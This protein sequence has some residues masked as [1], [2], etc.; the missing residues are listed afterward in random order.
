MTEAY[1]YYKLTYEPKGSGELKNKNKDYN[2]YGN[3]TPVIVVGFYPKITWQV[4]CP[5]CFWCWKI[6][7]TL[8]LSYQRKVTL[9]LFYLWWSFNGQCYLE[10]KINTIS[11]EGLVLQTPTLT[12]AESAGHI[13]LRI[14][15]VIL[16]LLPTPT[17][18][19]S[20]G[21]GPIWLCFIHVKPVTLQTPI[22]SKPK[23]RA[24]VLPIWLC[25][26]NT[27]PI[28]FANSNPN[29]NLRE[30]I[31]YDYAMSM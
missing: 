31:V 3:W 16:S 19:Q 13:W 27:N 17:L 25:F 5:F 21:A 26:I 28:T 24:Q 30:Q 1:L 4:T 8:Q 10:R 15:H 22:L 29:Q 2:K 12:Q 18:N 7:D 14:I 20:L 9:N 6:N 11:S 23:L